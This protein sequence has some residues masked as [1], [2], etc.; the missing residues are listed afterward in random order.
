MISNQQ[1]IAMGILNNFYVVLPLFLIIG[2]GYF[3]A[4]VKLLPNTTAGALSKFSFTVTIPTLLFRTMADIAHLPPPNWLIAVAFFG[5]CF[6]VFGIGAVLGKTLLKLNGEGQTI[7]GMAG[8]FSN[9]VQL[10][11]PITISLLGKE[12]MPSIAVIFSL[13][14]FLMWTLA[15]VAIEIA[16]NKSP[17]FRQTLIDGLK[18]TIKNPIVVGI[19]LGTVWGFTG[20]DLPVPVQKSVELL[21]NSAA[22]VAL[23]AVGA[24][25]ASY[26]IT[27]NLNITTCIIG[28]K[29]GLQPCVVFVLCH[30]LGLNLHETQAACLLSCLPVGVNVYIMAQEFNVMQE[31]TANALLVTTALAS[32]T[33][34]ITLGLFGLL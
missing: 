7:F 22:P 25:L 11:I 4:K 19:I 1:E 5:S 15:T 14:G 6:I 20:L 13:N 10:G 31:A 8:V 30:L 9:N 32:I 21:A 12:A 34:P 33:L 28:L 29:L 16:R 18:S 24:G 17:S 23:F 26:K 3:C 27:S 2:F